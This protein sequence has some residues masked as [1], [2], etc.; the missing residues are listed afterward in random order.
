M[1]PVTGPFEGGE[2]FYTAFDHAPFNGG[3]S[4]NVHFREIA[5]TWFRQRRPYDLPLAYSMSDRRVVDFTTPYPPNYRTYQGAATYNSSHAVYATNKAY[6]KMIAAIGDASLWAVNVIQ[7][8]QSFSLIEE[9]ATTLWRF[10]RALNRFNFV[11]AA[12][13][14][15]T[16]VPKGLKRK[17]SAF[18]G[19]W[20]KFHF[21]WEPLIKDIG[22]SVETLQTSQ[23]SK[24][25]R[26]RGN[27]S[28]EDSYFNYLPP[29][30]QKDS[31]QT[32]SR[33]EQGCTVRVE[34]PNLYLA[35]QL[36]FVN[37]L[38]VVWELMKF[39]FVIDWFANV[40]QFLSQWT[41]FI[42]M[43]VSHAYTTITQTVKKTEE[44]YNGIVAHYH[45]ATMIRTESLSAPVLRIAPFR[46]FSP[47]RGATALSLV[48]QQLRRAL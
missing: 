38:G 1:N 40:G 30:W 36:G 24:K 4:A 17:A 12:R 27:F 5:R 37:P 41:D 23:F 46:G 8:K 9:A 33:C 39:S 2:S 16:S 48:V 10:G 13:L 25:I 15:G 34:N 29:F 6:S 22:A 18:G 26:G 45:T 7:Y 3:Y 44:W 14:L 11:E 28:N 32:V 42:G 31:F 19:N 43:V 47:V 35:N 20:L 21:G